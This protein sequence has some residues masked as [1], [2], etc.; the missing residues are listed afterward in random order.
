MLRNKFGIFEI[1][2]LFPWG[3]F[4]YHLFSFL[5]TLVAEVLMPTC[6]TANRTRSMSELSVLALVPGL[7]R[8]KTW[9]APGFQWLHVSAHEKGVR[10]LLTRSRSIRTDQSI[11]R[12]TV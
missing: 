11:R 12:M 3:V 7:R 1:F 5:A 2:S 6:I 4:R 8:K 10:M 9:S